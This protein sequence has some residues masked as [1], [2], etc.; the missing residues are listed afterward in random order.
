VDEVN[1]DFESPST[2]IRKKEESLKLEVFGNSD[3]AI[4][5]DKDADIREL[6]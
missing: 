1:S 4:D 2:P 6:E 5:F 3:D